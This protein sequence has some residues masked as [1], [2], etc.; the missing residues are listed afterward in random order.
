MPSLH[1]PS[2]IAAPA[3]PITVSS[4]LTL[5]APSLHHQCPGLLQPAH[6]LFRHAHRCFIIYMALVFAQKAIPSVHHHCITTACAIAAPPLPCIIIPHRFLGHGDPEEALDTAWNNVQTFL[7]IVY[8]TT[9]SG[10]I[11]LPSPNRHCNI[12]VQW[13]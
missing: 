11:T 6:L 9:A 8:P 2:L 3:L 12:T 4:L 10:T 13:C 7:F 1:A 5:A